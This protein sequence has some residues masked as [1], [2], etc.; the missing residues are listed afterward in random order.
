MLTSIIPANGQEDLRGWEWRH[1]WGQTCGDDTAE[2]ACFN[3]GVFHVAFID[4]DRSVA[5]GLTGA[6]LLAA[7]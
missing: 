6:A 5:V 2:I 7:N 3:G 4:N 1:L